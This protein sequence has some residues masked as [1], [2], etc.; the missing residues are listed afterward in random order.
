MNRAPLPTLYP[1]LK[2]S[3]VRGF[4]QPFSARAWKHRPDEG[5]KNQIKHRRVYCEIILLIVE[6]K[7][8]NKL[9]VV[10]CLRIPQLKF[11]F[12]LEN[13]PL[14]TD[15]LEC[16]NGQEFHT[17]LQQEIM[18]ETLAVFHLFAWSLQ[19]SQLSQQSFHAN[20]RWDPGESCKGKWHHL[21]D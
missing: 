14:D 13:W 9:V 16:M 21:N 17:L 2:P 15:L 5:G 10:T 3:N 1:V 11:D 8:M 12:R 7:A 18:V 19:Y 4:R 20:V 6:S